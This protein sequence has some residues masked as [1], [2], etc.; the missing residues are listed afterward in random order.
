MDD[1]KDCSS[2]QEFKMEW[3]RRHRKEY[4]RVWCIETEETCGGFPDVL[5]IRKDGRAEL[6]EF[7]KAKA[8][9][10]ISFEP[11][12]PAFFMAN[13][14][15]VPIRVVAMRTDGSC[16][17]FSASRMMKSGLMKGRRLDLDMM[18]AYLEL[19]S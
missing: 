12:Q 11:T 17:E 19:A 14:P 6:C 7:K 16:M 10:V 1:Y 8:G 13:A 9:D 5:C 2:E 15:A 3:I 18:A 4:S